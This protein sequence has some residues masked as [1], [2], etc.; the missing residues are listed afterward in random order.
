MKERPIIMSYWSVRAILDG[1][2][3]QTRRVCKPQPEC[4]VKQ[5]SAGNY[6]DMHGGG[7][8]WLKPPCKTGDRL[9]VKET[10]FKYTPDDPCVYAA[11]V[12]CSAKYPTPWYE[13]PEHV[14]K[15]YVCIWCEMNNGLI[16]W[17]P[18]MFMPRKLSR[19]TLEVVSVRLEELQDVSIADCIAEGITEEYSMRSEIRNW[20][21]E[22][23][24]KLNAKRGFPWESNPY[25]WVID[26]R[27]I[28]R[29]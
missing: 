8:I 16:R 17:K 20:Y 29:T 9:W 22:H 28:E 1:R 25:V 3:T 15:T 5:D 21:R 10:W 19:L 4:Y 27:Q 12:G 24:D 2:K 18:S 6:G 13:C 11:D 23:W 14:E 7:V 26:F